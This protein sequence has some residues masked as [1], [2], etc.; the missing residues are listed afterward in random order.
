MFGGDSNNDFVFKAVIFAVALLILTPTC[1]NV[2]VEQT[3]D[4]SSVVQDALSGY[5]NFT[6]A[7]VAT[8][9]EVW[10]LNGIYTPY[11]LDA[12]GNP[13]TAY[14]RTS[15]N[16]IAGARIVDYRPSQYNGTDA[17]Y[18]VVYDTDDKVYR[19][20]VTG[21]TLD[22]HANGELYSSVSMDAQQKSTMFYTS[23]GKHADGSGFW[24]DY[25]GYRY[26]FTPLNDFYV[27]DQNGDTKNVIATS[28][29]LSCIWY[30]YY[31]SE[32]IAGQLVLTGQDTGVSYLT[33]TEIIQA[34]NA[35]T[36][37]AKFKMTFNGGVQTNIY[38]KISPYF[39]SQG[40]TIEQ[41]FNLGYWDLMVTSYSTDVSSYLSA[42]YSLNID[43]IWNTFVDLFTF[44][45]D[46]YNMSPMVGTVASVLVCTCLYGILLSLAVTCWPILIIAGLVAIAQAWVTFD[47]GS[48]FGI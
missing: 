8:N 25:T 32:G 28:T 12:D 4:A 1:I 27:V 33:A 44:N 7:Q 40:F 41:C 24:Y 17:S 2:F 13:S 45:T 6:G 16:W 21:T 36:T 14:M 31:G 15:D 35:E 42:E 3:T 29:S 23:S 30:N 11:G 26:A 46:K 22:G 18:K 10:I 37:T 43:N 34:F 39:L 5:Y 20:S 48:M 38:V 47:I 19:Y 9:E